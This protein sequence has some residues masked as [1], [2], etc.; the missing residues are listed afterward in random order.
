[1]NFHKQG[2]LIDC[3]HFEQCS[4]CQYEVWDDLPIYAQAKRFFLSYGVQLPFIQGDPNR[5]RVR[6]KLAIRFDGKIHIGLFKKGTHNVLSIPNCQVHHPSI[7]ELTSRIAKA[8]SK[9]GLSI[10]NETTFLGDLRYMQSVVQRETRKVQL[11][12]VLNK[13]SLGLWKDF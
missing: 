11:S 8:L 4:G 1:M 3:P 13:D 10:Y 9:E 6:A 2:K 7:N 5:W 12:I